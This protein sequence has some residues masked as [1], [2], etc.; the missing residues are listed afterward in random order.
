[1]LCEMENQHRLGAKWRGVGGRTVPKVL[2]N[3]FYCQVSHPG[4]YSGFQVTGMI[5]W[6]QKSR[7][8]KI[9]KACSENSKNAWTKS[10]A[11]FMALK[12]SR[13]G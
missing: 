11:D 10:H 4:G 7:S 5:E 13:K 12:T 3:E 6:S 1:M 9:S 8:K 2:K